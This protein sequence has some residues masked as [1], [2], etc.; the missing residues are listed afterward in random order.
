M[1]KVHRT[2][3]GPGKP[4]EHDCRDERGRAIR[5]V[6]RS[7]ALCRNCNTWLVYVRTA[8]TTRRRS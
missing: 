4:V 6:A 1:P 5:G 8:E 2:S 7:N 3:I